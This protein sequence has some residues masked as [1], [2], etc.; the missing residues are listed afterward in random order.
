MGRRRKEV[1]LQDTVEAV[2]ADQMDSAADVQAPVEAEVFPESDVAKEV[3]PV[4]KPTKWVVLEDKTV[5][6]FGQVTLLPAGTVVSAAS[7]GPIGL[8][9]I[10]EQGVMLEPVA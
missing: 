7:Y 10:M 1:A 9:R 8:K 2:E 6:L 5:S 4:A 3:A